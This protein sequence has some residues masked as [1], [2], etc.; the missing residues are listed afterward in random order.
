MEPWDESVLDELCALLPPKQAADARDFLDHNEFG[1]AF[2]TAVDHLSEEHVPITAAL[3]TRV[4]A[5]AAHSR[6]VLDGLRFCPD[7]DQP[8]WRV[9]EDTWEG[10][11]IEE[12]LPSPRDVAWLA[13]NR[14]PE[15]LFRFDSHAAMMGKVPYRCG[16]LGADGG[17]TE[18][19]SGQDLLARLERCWA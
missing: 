4:A 10:L 16:I 12:R 18:L 3:R 2:E 1:L 5:T 17:I 14:C 19:A 6:R 15:V 9:V 11:E 7:A 8:R 13:C